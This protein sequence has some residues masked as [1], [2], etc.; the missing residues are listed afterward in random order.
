MNTDSVPIFT[1]ASRVICPPFH[2]TRASATEDISVTVDV[3]RAL[4]WVARMPV[5]RMFSVSARK[6]PPMRSSATSVLMARTP[7]MPSLK[8]PVILEL[9]SRICRFSV[10]S[11]PWNQAI[12]AAE[13]GIS[14]NS[15]AVS[16]GL[17]SN[18]ISTMNSR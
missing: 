12:S 17:A 1:A 9:I 4:K 11:F 7:V 3:K 10:T 13:T 5:L 6:S 15:Q 2:S 18:I 16:R 14:G 8:L